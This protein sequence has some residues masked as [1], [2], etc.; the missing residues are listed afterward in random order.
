MRIVAGIASLPGR[1]LRQAVQSLLHQVD[2]VGV[3]LNGYSAVPGWLQQL[4]DSSDVPVIRHEG[5][6]GSSR[7]LHWA[8]PQP[9][10]TLYLACDDDLEYPPDYV[11]RMREESERWGHGVIVTACGRTLRPDARGWRDWQGDGRYVS[12][13]PEGRWINYLGGCAFAFRPDALELP[14]IDPPN[15]EEAVLSAWAQ[16]RGIPIRLL[17]RPHDWPKRIPLVP[18]SFTL[19]EQAA[20]DRFTTRSAIIRTVARWNVHLPATVSV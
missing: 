4:S 2:S 6:A 12:A 17:A 11:A 8:T 16:E 9:P 13:V 1:P 20:R 7:K 19:Y 15:E 10:D 18:G 5:N 3:W 14:F